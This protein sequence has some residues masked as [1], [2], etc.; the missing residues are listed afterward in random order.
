MARHQPPGR[1]LSTQPDWLLV[2]ATAVLVGF[3]YAA[4]ADVIGVLRQGGGWTP[5]T[6]PP[7]S[8][9]VHFALAALLLGAVPVLA[10][11]TLC[12][13]RL[14]EL[15][16]GLGRWRAGL[17]WLAVGVPLAVLA[18]WIGADSAA[19][20]AVYPL[21]P[22]LSPR[23]SDMGPHALRQWLYF[24]AWETLFRGVLLFGLR[25]RVGAG[26]ANLMQTALSVVAH[27]GRPLD[28]TLA[29]VPAGL[30]FGWVDLRIGS[31]WYVALIHWVVGV[32]LDW[33]MLLG[34]PAG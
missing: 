34:G 31:I 23:L 27:F 14:T 9:A 7:H 28:E 21:D 8:P 26:T 11:R 29:A 18:G 2:I 32:A 1:F 30:V 6:L 20:R 13:L 15:G 4:R 5:V 19:V 17:R 12:G 25:A 24:A 22:A 3:H 33:F 10:A 16:L